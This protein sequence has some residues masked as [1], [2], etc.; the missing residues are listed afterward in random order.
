MPGLPLSP[1]DW[2]LLAAFKEA[3]LFWIESVGLINPEP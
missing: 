2:N 3:Q 1:I